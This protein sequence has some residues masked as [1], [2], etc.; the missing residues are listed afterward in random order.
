[1][2]TFPDV[3][4]FCREEG[5]YKSVSVRIFLPPFQSS[6]SVFALVFVLKDEGNV[7]DPLDDFESGPA[8]NLLSSSTAELVELNRNDG[9]VKSC[10]IAFE[11][12][13]LP[14]ELCIDGEAWADLDLMEK[15]YADMLLKKIRQHSEVRNYPAVIKT[16]KGASREMLIDVLPSLD[17]EDSVVLTFKDV[18]MH[19]IACRHLHEVLDNLP[20]GVF[21]KDIGSGLYQLSN[22]NANQLLNEGAPLRGQS[23]EGLLSDADVNRVQQ[24]LNYDPETGALLISEPV[25]ILN[26]RVEMQHFPLHDSSGQVKRLVGIVRELSKSEQAGADASE[27]YLCNM[28]HEFRTP[29]N[30]ILG[31]TSLLAETALQ[32]EQ[33]ELLDTVRASGEALSHTVDRMLELAALSGNKLELENEPMEVESF[34]EDLSEAYE[35]EAADKGL[36]LTVDLDTS[37]PASIV[38][39][40]TQLRRLLDNLVEN[41][42]KFTPEGEVSIHAD[43]IE[44]KGEL[45]SIQFSVSDTGIGIPLDKQ[46]IIFK[47]FQQGDSSDSRAYDGTGMSLTVSD[48]IARAM[49]SR[50]ELAS[51]PGDGS[52]FSFQLQIPFSGEDTVADLQ[53]VLDGCAVT[54][55]GADSDDVVLWERMLKTWGSE[56]RVVNSV[57][58]FLG[59]LSEPGSDQ[60]GMCLWDGLDKITSGDDELKLIEEA[61]AG[62]LILLV[63]AESDAKVLS[64]E[65]GADRVIP[66]RGRSSILRSCIKDY[67]TS[68]D[69]LAETTSVPA[70]KTLKV[71]RPLCRALI[72]DNRSTERS[73]F[74]SHLRSFG[75]DVDL[76]ETE[77]E[78]SGLLLAHDYKVVFF[79]ANYVGAD[80]PAMVA[81]LRMYLDRVDEVAFVA[82]AHSSREAVDRM[83]AAAQVDTF[84]QKPFKQDELKTLLE[85]LKILPSA[86]PR[87]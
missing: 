23:E 2:N 14:D 83:L 53:T 59:S 50:I 70:P 8:D 74:A 41:A 7:E 35:K 32:A 29:M 78:A 13:N 69:R 45:A 25:K 43:L 18:T 56:V 64:V 68:E 24:S 46:R 54:V 72:L 60:V 20:M 79:E 80:T 44:V 58:D 6:K 66:A 12:A 19:N 61:K 57:K 5:A 63:G 21:T 17:D 52:V 71:K 67:I 86:E 22:T 49:G 42:I 9:V 39:D 34:M 81:G 75:V 85:E 1:V 40:A 11:E 27:Q 55:L 38:T 10:S 33:Q 77:R 26:D 36:R 65:V 30:A 4:I 15:N 37:L 16:S 84:L 47:A 82:V 87:E 3:R 48:R 76:C 31:F 62:R 51:R 28:G 73:E